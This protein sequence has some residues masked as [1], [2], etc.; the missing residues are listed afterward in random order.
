MFELVITS[1][2]N[3][4]GEG[5][6]TI[7]ENDEGI[8]TRVSLESKSP[9][10]TD[11]EFVVKASPLRTFGCLHFC[12]LTTDRAIKATFGASGEFRKAEAI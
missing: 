12:G 7:W 11:F 1:E 4:T 6:V 10:D 5:F 3:K 9:S 2:Q 8:I